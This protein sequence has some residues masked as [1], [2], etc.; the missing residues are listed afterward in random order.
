MKSLVVT[1]IATSFI[2]LSGCSTPK[3]NK[4]VIKQPEQT[5]PQENIL[6]GSLEGIVVEITES[7]TV[8]IRLSRDH[9]SVP[10]GIQVNPEGII[11][12]GFATLNLPI[13]EKYHQALETYLL[14]EK[15]SFVMENHGDTDLKTAVG[16]ILV[17]TAGAEN[18]YKAVQE[19]LYEDVL[20]SKLPELN[21]LYEK[22][23][24]YAEK[25]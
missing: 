15:V 18:S 21:E 20:L 24:Q 23:L 4:E 10:E 6:I 1:T 14:N 8:R 16:Q 13:D 9:G 12:V 11:E 25:H 19:Y 17:K 7:N 3:Y 2:L 5:Y 22:I